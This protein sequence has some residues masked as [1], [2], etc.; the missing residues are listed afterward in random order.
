MTRAKC[1]VLF[2]HP[3]LTVESPFPVSETLL[4]VAK[5]GCSAH[6]WEVHHVDDLSNLS[7]TKPVKTMMS[8]AT[9]FPILDVD[10]FGG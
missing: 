10:G 5:Y 8:I 1:G 2:T 6:F 7:K 9:G 4:K 3:S